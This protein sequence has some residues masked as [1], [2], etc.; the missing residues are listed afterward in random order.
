[1]ENR[2]TLKHERDKREIEKDE[3]KYWEKMAEQLQTKGRKGP[4]T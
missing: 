1:M 3:L 4:P 2:D